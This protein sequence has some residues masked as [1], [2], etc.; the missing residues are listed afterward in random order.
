[1]DIK[2]WMPWTWPSSAAIHGGEEPMRALQSD[3]NRAFETFWQGF[4]RRFKAD[5]KV[6]FD[7]IEPRIDLIETDGA[8]DVIA[9]LPGF[10][11]GEI[12]IGVA[13]DA[14]TIIAEPKRADEPGNSAEDTAADK[15]RRYLISERTRGGL[16]RVIPLPVPCD[17][18]SAEARLRNGILTITIA[19]AVQDATAVK[20]IAV[21]KV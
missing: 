21:V 16:R 15:G 20:R 18:D 2:R 8:I 9:D 1:M 17:D 3:I 13:P 5:W 4:P 19:K 11:E 12:E 10:E 6:S 14:L 7:N